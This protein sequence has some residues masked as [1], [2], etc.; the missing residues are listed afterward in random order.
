[1]PI[2]RFAEGRL[3]GKKAVPPSL[4]VT[5]RE[6]DQAEQNTHSPS[7]TISALSSANTGTLASLRLL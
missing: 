5:Q 2:E 6:L 4:V 3:S 7:K 1:V